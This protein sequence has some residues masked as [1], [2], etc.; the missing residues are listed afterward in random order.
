M[1]RLQEYREKLNLTQSELAEKSG[2]S[3]RTIQRIEAGAKPKGYTL[4]VLSE[5]LGITREQLTGEQIEQNINYQLIKLINLSSLLFIILP[6]GNIILP[7]IMMYRKKQINSLTKQIVSI[8][9]LWTIISG[10]LSLLIPF[11]NRLFSLENVMILIVVIVSLLLN[12]YIIIQNTIAI[13][14]HHQLFIRLNFSFI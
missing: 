13:D 9:I 10:L 4:K 8:Q 7:L 6:P 5:T 14:K 12:L 2:V 11:I 1:S 3:V